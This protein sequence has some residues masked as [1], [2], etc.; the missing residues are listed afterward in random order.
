MP[1]N[2]V[3]ETNDFQSELLET[4]TSPAIATFTPHTP[5]PSESTNTGTKFPPTFTPMALEELITLDCS[6][7]FHLMKLGGSNKPQDPTD[8]AVYEKTA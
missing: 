1:T 5:I 2:Q 7:A 3:T 8:L 6:P 4:V